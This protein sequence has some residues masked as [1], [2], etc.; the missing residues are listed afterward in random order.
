MFISR[1]GSSCA[2]HTCPQTLI[3]AH[4]DVTAFIST[5]RTGHS[6]DAGGLCAFLRQ[7]ERFAKLTAFTVAAE[8]TEPEEIRD[9][10]C[11]KCS[12]A[13]AHQEHLPSA[14]HL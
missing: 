8:V 7:L 5:D 1:S 10:A 6:K 2:R 4:T 12:E 3:S 11:G 14:L 9:L 13:T